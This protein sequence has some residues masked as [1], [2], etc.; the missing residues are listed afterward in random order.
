MKTIRKPT[1]TLS[2]VAPIAVMTKPFPCPHGSCIYCPGGPRV[3]TPKSY[4]GEEP[5]LMRAK[6]RKF[7]PYMQVYDR[8]RQYI[9][10]GHFPSKVEL[11]VMGGTFTFFPYNYKRWFITQCFQALNNYPKL[12]RKESGL[13][14]AQKLN[15]R[16]SFRCVG[17]TLE[18]RPDQINVKQI[19]EMLNLGCTRVEI[20]VQSIYDD[21]LEIVSRGHGVE[22]TIKA[23]KMLRDAG[24]KVCYHI[25]PNLPGSNLQRDYRMFKIIFEDP[26]FKPDM[27]KIYPTLVMNGTL[28]YKWWKDGGYNPP[29]LNEVIDLLCKVKSIVPPWI[30]I[31]RIQ[32]DVP[33]PII[34]AGVKKSN[35]RQLVK[36]EMERRG[37]KC[38]CI[39]CR[40]AQR[41]GKYPHPSM[42]KVKVL[43]YEAGGG[44]EYFISLE[45]DDE[46]LVGLL[47]LRF[48][49]NPEENPFIKV[50]PIIR[51]LH[52]YGK[53]IPVGLKDEFSSQ[54]KGFGSLLLVEAE[55]IALNEGYK[56]IAVLPGVGARPYYYRKGYKQLRGTP[57]L[58]KS[59]S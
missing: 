16:A 50:N 48:N 4:I 1:R 57:Y 45:L 22:A 12:N 34:E 23:T 6:R 20:G 3:G 24:L 58:V 25:M 52:V 37:L 32:R 29:T 5:A 43:K 54:H 36:A 31:M 42:T 7:H 30:R 40:E 18:T 49:P 15:E 35:L 8:I 51:E 9:L 41:R 19:Q 44:L 10:L 39:R 11:I 27:L 13:I 28:L 47:R 21:V 17:L 46:S 2:G 59:L 55:E 33:S 14:E 38:R 56:K 53:Q 26:R